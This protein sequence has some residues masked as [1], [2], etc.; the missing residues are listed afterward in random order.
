MKNLRICQEI[1]CAIR[2]FFAGILAFFEKISYN[3]SINSKYYCR[4]G[5]RFFIG[6]ACEMDYQVMRGMV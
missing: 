2:V 5:A 1:S 4:M 3:V 6:A